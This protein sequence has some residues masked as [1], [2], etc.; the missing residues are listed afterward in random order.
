MLDQKI[1]PKAGVRVRAY[2]ISS[3]SIA[4][5]HSENAFIDMILRIGM[6]RSE[7]QKLKTG[8]MLM[9]ELETNVEKLLK[10]GFLALALEIIEIDSKFSWKM[11]P[12]HKRISAIK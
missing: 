11:N 3:Y 4:D 10:T 1:F 8:E 2:P 12:I 6:G 7:D 5:G 9:M